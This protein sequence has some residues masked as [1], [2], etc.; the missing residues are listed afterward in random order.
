MMID[1]GCFFKKYF[2]IFLVLTSLLLF[3]ILVLSS[4]EKKVQRLVGVE[5]PSNVDYCRYIKFTY[6]GVIFDIRG[7]GLSGFSESLIKE[8]EMGRAF[9]GNARSTATSQ[10]RSFGL[11]GFSD[12]GKFYIGSKNVNWLFVQH[13]RIIGGRTPY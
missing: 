12:K 6:R 2:L 13:G 1:W 4:D 7:R 11:N 3:S 8:N 10:I 5:L 9:G